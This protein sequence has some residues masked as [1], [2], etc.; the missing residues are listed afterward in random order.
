[1]GIF[2]SKKKKK[3]YTTEVNAVP[4]FDEN[5]LEETRKKLVLDYLK[6]GLTG[7]DYVQSYG[8]TGAAQ[9]FEYYLKGKYEYMDYLP[10][11]TI[12]AIGVPSSVM[13][14]IV[15]SIESEPIVVTKVDYI[16]PDNRLWI[17][18]QLQ[19]M[20]GYDIGTDLVKIGTDYYSY[21][22]YDYTESNDTFQAKLSTLLNLTITTRRVTKKIVKTYNTTSDISVTTISTETTYTDTDTGE[23]VAS[24]NVVN[25]ETTS[26]I[27]I[28]SDTSSITSTLL[29]T[30]IYTNP[31]LSTTIN[32]PG[33][34]DGV[35]Q[36]ILKYTILNTGKQKFWI[37][38]PNT[39]NYPQL[40]VD[41]YTTATYE[42]YPITCFRNNVFSIDEYD[43]NSKV[44]NSGN[45]PETVYRTSS[46]TEQRY[47]ETEKL[48]KAI[49]IGIED[50]LES[51]EA[52]PD[53]D[54]L[55]DGFIMIGVQ[56][57]NDAPIVSRALYEM[58]EYLY[59]VLP[60]TSVGVNVTYRL[61]IDEVPY[62]SDYRWIPQNLITSN[63]VIGLPGTYTHEVS[64]ESTFFEIITVVNYSI[65]KVNSLWGPYIA[66]Y[67]WF[68]GEVD[69]NTGNIVTYNVITN[70]SGIKTITRT[71]TS[72][73]PSMPPS[74]VTYEIRPIDDNKAEAVVK[75][76]VDVE[77][78][79]M[80]HQFN[81]TQTNTIKIGYFSPDGSG[82]SWFS[83]SRV[84]VSDLETDVRTYLWS[85]VIDRNNRSGQINLGFNDKRLVIPL[86]V[87]AVEQLSYIERTDLMG[88]GV[89][90]LFYA[91]QYDEITYYSGGAFGGFL[92]I[93]SIVIAIVVAITTSGLG[94]ALLGLV[95][96]SGTTIGASLASAAIT[97]L[98]KGLLIGLV[99]SLVIKIVGS[100]INSPMLRMIFTVA[101][102]IAAMYVGGSF[103]NFEFNLK[104]AAQLA[105][106]PAKA[107]NA[108]TG[109]IGDNLQD[110][111]N[112]LQSQQQSFQD[113]Y[114]QISEQYSDTLKG[115]STGLSA[116]DIVGLNTGSES[117]ISSYIAS[118]SML[119]T[120]TFDAYKNFDSLYYNPVTDFVNQ[121]LKLGMVDY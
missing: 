47:K 75:V 41:D 79:I 68:D 11:S 87:K 37:Y 111:A 15:Q 25:S 114:S 83:G 72:T 98:L 92:G 103:E 102:T 93:I 14:S 10:T 99:L 118:P 18:Y 109:A 27:P 39:N 53:I 67:V 100:K 80:K 89:F 54:K 70:S 60:P 105:E 21:A 120:M 13:T 95:A 46:L 121:R 55:Q 116:G 24:N 81:Y 88:H 35:A 90:M 119:Y 36:Y 74:Y 69:I 42:T 45:V 33:Y 31:G 66:E 78:L 28:D 115:L 58:F 65:S 91:A 101:A 20:I 76:P 57:Y 82:F 38:D 59:K 97:E 16:L 48:L 5:L 3:I 23:I 113:Q 77:Y 6:K 104:T 43:I 19:E 63:E 107:M 110:S 64:Q 52:N 34:P 86:P 29:S 62:N 8:N 51:V 2:G 85:T 9:F 112:K 40:K 50:L 1:M 49:G 4:V 32:V 108:Y 106:I 71:F 12:G 26:Y 117:I 44:I 61:N 96:G 94:S 30:D 73:D 7:L 22:D 56:P 17:T 84:S